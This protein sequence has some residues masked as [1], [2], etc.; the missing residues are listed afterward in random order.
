MFL[1]AENQ[2]K[3]V[4]SGNNFQEISSLTSAS[5]PESCLLII[6]G[7]VVGVIV[8]FTAG[9]IPETTLT[10]NVFFLFML[11]P[12]VLEAG[13]FMP[14]RLFFNNLGT[15]LLMA[16]VGTVF[17]TVTIGF[18]LYGCG[19]T[20]SRVRGQATAA[21]TPRLFTLCFTFFKYNSSFRRGLY[22]WVDPSFPENIICQKGINCSSKIISQTHFSNFCMHFRP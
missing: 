7:I 4:F 2:R 21:A 16:I 9:Q 1:G 17:N 10:P 12:I 8:F 15:I 14:N 3:L 18:S 13:Y 6:L 11:P 5:V 20:G 19:L 22:F